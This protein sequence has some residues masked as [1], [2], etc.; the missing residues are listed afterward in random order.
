MFL[1]M[2]VLFVLGYAAIAL[3]HNIKVNKTASALF[4]GV[5]LWVLLM[6]DAGGIL[7]TDIGGRFGEFINSHPE[8][9]SLPK[10]EQYVNYIAD[11]QILG[12]LGEISEILFFLMGAMTIVEIVDQ[13]GGFKIITNR[14]KTRN[15]VKLLWIISFVTFFLS[16]VLDNLTTSIVMVAL[17]RKLIDGKHDR[18]LYAGMVILAANAGGAW[19][20]IGDVTTIMLWIK[21]NVT[22]AGIIPKLFF[23]SLVSLIVPLV[24]LS[25]TL[26]GDF[27]QS[28]D[29]S[30]EKVHSVTPAT[31]RERHLIFI[32]GVGALLFT[33]VFKVLTHLPP[34]MGMLLGL[35]VLWIFTEVMYHRKHNLD[36]REKRTVTRVIK[37]VDVPT[38][39]FF[40]GILM[41]VDALQTAGHLTLLSQ[42][43]DRSFTSPYPPNILIGLLSS[44]VDNVPL[45]AAA[46]GM[47]PAV[48]PDLV[49]TASAISSAY[50]ADGDFWNLLAYCAGTGG[51][52]LI[53][54]SAAGVAVMGLEKI[55]FMWYLK[56]ISLLALLGYFAGILT[57][58][59]MFG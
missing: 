5:A 45:V 57:Y 4:L 46:M 14:I 29:S 17:L 31:R 6:L 12:F 16:A 35:S 2:V 26:K 3:E 55:D 1:L 19:S 34:F 15:K 10:W 18:W 9:A 53:I 39:L 41:A 50:V 8:L 21:G 30:S 24:A 32:L 33:P 49:N 7:G 40:L 22:T 42:W 11:N 20:P 13:H 59:L 47:H 37:N 43:L 48:S 38:I 44:V 54:G 23:A 27:A 56:H 58:F 36:E 28:L 52:I 51:S 25:F